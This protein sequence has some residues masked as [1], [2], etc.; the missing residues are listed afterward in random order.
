MV[1][2]ELREI[3][4]KVEKQTSSFDPDK[5]IEKRIDSLAGVEKGREM[6]FDEADSGHVNPHYPGEGYYDNCQT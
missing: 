4:P 6:T 3:A 2:P 1:L 5:R